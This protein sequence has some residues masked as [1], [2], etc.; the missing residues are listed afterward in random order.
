M[1]NEPLLHI[2]NSVY[3]RRNVI[4]G[5]YERRS[6]VKREIM[7]RLMCKPKGKGNKWQKRYKSMTKGEFHIGGNIY[8]G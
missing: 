3:H 2:W 4:S 7:Q 8:V 6:I 1:T 5:R